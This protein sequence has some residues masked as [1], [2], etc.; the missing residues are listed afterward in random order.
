M[1]DFIDILL[2]AKLTW[3]FILYFYGV[4]LVLLVC[5]IALQKLLKV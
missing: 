1:I 4:M 5:V 2:I 3:P